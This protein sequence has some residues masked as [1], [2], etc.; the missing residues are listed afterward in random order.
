MQILFQ[1]GG[2]PDSGLNP[3]WILGRRDG[4]DPVFVMRTEAGLK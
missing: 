2:S 4:Q 1:L 3:A